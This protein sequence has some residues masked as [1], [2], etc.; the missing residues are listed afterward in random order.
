MSPS[1]TKAS[2]AE[3]GGSAREVV[4]RAGA[5]TE[6][7]REDRRGARPARSNP[8]AAMATSAAKKAGRASP[9]RRMGHE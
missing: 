5:G 4:A 9:R 8:A 7:R 2:R 3:A 6:V 1:R